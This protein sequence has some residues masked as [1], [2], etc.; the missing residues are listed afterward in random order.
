[1]TVWVIVNVWG[2]VPFNEAG[3]SWIPFGK[4]NDPE[5][6]DFDFLR[7]ETLKIIDRAEQRPQFNAV[8]L[9]IVRDGQKEM[10]VMLLDLW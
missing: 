1:M 5:S 6:L 4:I 2:P 10:K 7:E 8:R 9:E 3:Y